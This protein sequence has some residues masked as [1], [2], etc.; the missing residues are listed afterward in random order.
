MKLLMVL[1]LT[2]ISAGCG[3][4]SSYNNMNGGGVAPSITQLSPSSGPANTAF[5]LTITGRNF[6][7]GSVVYWNGTAVAASGTSYTSTTTLQAQI[8]AAMDA[9]AGQVPVYVHSTGGNSNTVMFT[10]Q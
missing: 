2:A 7:A 1:A 6:T 3:Y 4:G 8:S 5:T 10:V 9:T